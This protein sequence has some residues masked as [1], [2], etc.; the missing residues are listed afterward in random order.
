MIQDKLQITIAYPTREEVKRVG[1]LLH[2]ALAGTP[3]YAGTNVVLNVDGTNED[4]MPTLQIWVSKDATTVISPVFD[5]TTENKHAIVDVKQDAVLVTR[6]TT[7]GENN[8]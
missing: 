7:G 5:I 8:G 6:D 4:G 2:E 1:S 3:D